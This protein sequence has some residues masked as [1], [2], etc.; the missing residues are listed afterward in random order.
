MS[1][2]ISFQIRPANG[3]AVCKKT[4]LAFHQYDIISTDHF[5]Q[6]IMT[7]VHPAFLLVKQG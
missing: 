1:T 5:K 3:S 2:C 7:K 6:K 4:S